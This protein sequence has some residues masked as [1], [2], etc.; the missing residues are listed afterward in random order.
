MNILGL[1]EGSWINI[2]L[3][4]L[5]ILT[6]LMGVFLRVKQKADNADTMIKVDNKIAEDLRPVIK[7][8]DE[9]EQDFKDFKRDEIEPLKADMNS[10]KCKTSVMDTKIDSI[11]VGIDDIKKLFEKSDKQVENI[12]KVMQTKQDKK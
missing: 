7:K 9:H 8:I 10:L 6:T 4:V 5:G 11:L 2:G 12:W 3:A 1:A